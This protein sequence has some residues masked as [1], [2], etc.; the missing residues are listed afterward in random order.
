MGFPGGSV[1]KNPPDD[2][3]D[4]RSIPGSGR[5]PGVGNGNTLQ[6]QYSC[7]ENSMNRA[8]RATVYW[9][10][11]RHDWVTKHTHTHTL[12]NPEISFLG[13]AAWQR[14]VYVSSKK[15]KKGCFIASSIVFDIT[16]TRNNPMSTNSRAN[17]LVYS[18]GEMLYNYENE[19]RRQAYTWTPPDGQYQNQTDYTL[20]SQRWKSSI[21]P[22]KTRPRTDCGSTISS[23]LQNS[24]SNW[25]K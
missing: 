23:L 8:R 21:E 20:C 3:R 24:G 4:A 19:H 9:V 15:K 16:Q 22:A 13:L 6:I 17:K 25:R 12:H 2:A 7:L 18:Y 11:K 5:F 1:V 10:A 14:K